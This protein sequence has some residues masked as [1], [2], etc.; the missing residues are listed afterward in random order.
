MKRAS[1][2][3]SAILVLASGLTLYSSFASTDSENINWTIN[4]LKKQESQNVTEVEAAINKV[5]E[6]TSVTKFDM[7]SA[8]ARFDNVVFLGDSIT[9][10][11]RESGILSEANVLAQKGE[12]VSQ[13]S[14]HLSEIKSLKPSEIVILYGANDVTAYS[15]DVFKQE[16]IN[17]IKKIKEVDKNV[18][19]YVQAP[20]AVNE[21]I[22][23]SKDT[24]LNND[25]VAQFALKAKQACNI[26]GATYLDSSEL[27]PSQDVYEQDGIHFKYA[28]YKNWLHFLSENI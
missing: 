6:D 11:L 18:K 8:K 19:I 10:Y 13:A 3:A 2:L 15:P 7:K 1:I 14:K 20:I 22:A 16:Y 12:H 5:N 26:A 17:L 9:E 24:R 28:F 27:V 25:N 4:F 23:S 21:R